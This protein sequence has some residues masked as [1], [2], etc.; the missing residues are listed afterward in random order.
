MKIL[1]AEDD[2]ETGEYICNGLK[3]EGHVVDHVL[4]GRDALAQAM[5]Q[6]YDLFIFDR[7]MPELDGLSVVKSL[8]A[9]RNLAPVIFLTAMGGLDDRVEG[10]KAGADD[11]LVKPFALAELSARIQ[12][13]ARRPVLKEEVTELAVGD[14]KL[15]LLQRQATRGG[16]VIDL[17]P[18]EF[19][20]LE[21]FM[22]RPGRVLTRTMLLEAV[23]DV[24]FDPKTS[25]VETHISRLRAKMDKPFEKKLLQTLHGIGYMLKA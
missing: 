24:H 9:A 1:L 11:Y 14:L 5:V 2:Q 3:G 23:W 19:L 8:R 22:R 15:D 17:Q 13:I 25:V 20:L 21:H 4:N 12:A 6:D 16:A 18:R 7:M 10:L